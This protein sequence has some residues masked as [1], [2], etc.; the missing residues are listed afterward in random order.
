MRLRELFNN[1]TLFGLTVI[2]GLIFG[3]FFYDFIDKR[4]GFSYIDEIIALALTILYFSN[5]SIKT[6]KISDGL[7]L[8]IIAFSAMLAYSVK[9][10]YQPLPAILNDAASL[11]KPFLFYFCAVKFGADFPEAHKRFLVQIAFFGLFCCV[12]LGVFGESAINQVFIRPSRF[13][14]CVVICSFILLLFYKSYRPMIWLFIATLAVSILSFRSKA[15]GFFA[16]ATLFAVFFGSSITKR[17]F[18]ISKRTIAATILV[19]GITIFSSWEK[20]QFYFFEGSVA[21]N[22]FARPALYI[23][24]YDIA[25]DHFPLGGG[26]ASFASNAS[27]VNYSPLYYIYGMSEVDGLSYEN[28]YFAADSFYPQILG[29]FGFLGLLAFFAMG[30]TL[31]LQSYKFYRN[32][33]K[34]VNFIIDI[35]AISFFAIESIA[36][37]TFT[38]NRGAFMMLILGINHGSSLKNYYEQQYLAK[39]NYD[40]EI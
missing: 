21:D 25:Q 36:D 26:F 17:K 28:T 33:G 37:T 11:I 34:P 8:V 20:I 31:L 30:I 22:I 9:L 13:A 12:I 10:Q 2:F 29:Q 7:I 16:F 3:V 14:T 38:H 6:H 23:G 39:Q 35:L 18:R 32:N 19:G 40:P 1:K 27:A 15:I 4:I 24:A 5:D